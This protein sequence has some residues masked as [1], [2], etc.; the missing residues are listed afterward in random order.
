MSFKVLNSIILLGHSYKVIQDYDQEN[1]T[2][3]STNKNQ[4]EAEK[5]KETSQN[6]SSASANCESSS[7]DRRSHARTSSYDGK[8]SKTFSQIY[9]ADSFSEITQVNT[10]AVIEQTRGFKLKGAKLAYSESDISEEENQGVP[11]DFES[12]D[13]VYG[14]HG[15]PDTNQQY[16][17][18]RQINGTQ[19]PTV[20]NED[21]ARSSSCEHL[22]DSQHSLE[23]S[24]PSNE[25]HQN[26]Q[27]ATVFQRSQ[28]SFFMN[29][30][31]GKMYGSSVSLP[32]TV[33]VQECSKPDAAM[34][35]E[36]SSGPSTYKSKEVE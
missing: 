31:I 26:F 33:G 34:A 27:S 21:L 12:H 25:D 29:F 30:G 32:E 3:S 35:G 36:D 19:I 13:Q 2:E 22:L 5:P 6:G 9:A 24:K 10:D 18:D 14:S 15:E 4:E 20:S 17:S 11:N 8:I 16:F 23:G 1:Q 7:S 28:K